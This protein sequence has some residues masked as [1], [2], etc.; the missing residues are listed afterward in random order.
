M[1]EALSHLYGWMFTY[2]SHM[3]KWAAFPRKTLYFNGKDLNEHW[4][5]LYDKDI[6]KLIKIVDEQLKKKNEN[7]NG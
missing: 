6:N 4:E 5:V 7:N 1:K 3:G 2:N